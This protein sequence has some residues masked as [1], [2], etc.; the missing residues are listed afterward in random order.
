MKDEN[1]QLQDLNNTAEMALLQSAETTKAVQET[2]PALEGILIKTSELVDKLNPQEIGDN[3]SFSVVGKKGDKGDKGNTPTDDEL[4]SL[5][6][7]LIPAPIKGDDGKTPTEEELI[8]LIQPLIPA[9]I[10]GENYIL[11]EDD[12]KEIADS[13]EVPIV[14]KVIEKIEVIKE[15]LKKDTPTELKTKL[16]SLKTGLDYES[17]SNRPNIEQYIASIKQG[18]KTVSLVELDDVNLT[19]VTVTNGKYVLGSGSSS[20]PLTTKGDLYTYTTTDARLGIGTNG[21]FLKA[22]S[23][24]A[25]GLEWAAGGTG[26]VV[27]P[28][29]ATDNAITRYD[30]TTGKLIQ[31]SG[32]TLNDSGGIVAAGY[33]EAVVVKTAN[34]TA[35]ASDAL[36]LCETFANPGFTVTL[37][38][39]VGITGR[40][41]TVKDSG[42][43]AA[44]EAII[45]ACN[46]AQTIDGSATKT[47]SIAHGSI[48]VES[49]GT[50][51][52]TVAQITGTGGD[53]VLADAQTV[54]G[55]KTFLNTTMKLRNVANTFDGSFVNTNTADRIYT[56]QDRDGTLADDTDLALKAPLASPT[57]TGTV[58]VPTPSN[59]TDA[60][61]KAYVD[62]VAQGLSI[63]ESV[64]VATAATLPT[65]TYN[66]GASG[67][68]ATLTG[69]ATGVLTVDGLTVALNE[70]V[71]VKDEIT[72]AN[73]GIY[74][75][76]I[77]GA[78]GVAY[79]L[80]RS[81]NMNQAAEIPGAFTF[82]ENGTVNDSAGFVVADAGPFTIGTTAID[83]TQFSGAG[84]IIAGTG[85]T[86]TGN[87]LDVN[88]TTNRIVANAN[89]IDI[90]S[91]YV[92]QS[93]ITTLGTITTG[94]W[95]GTSIALNKI[96]AL[97][98]SQIVIT[99]ASGFLAS[100]AVATY[101]SLTELT[102][103]KGVTSA[104]QTQL[105]AKFTLPALTTGSVLFSDGTT[106]AQDNSNFFWDDTNNRLG[107][108]TTAPKTTFSILTTDTTG[109]VTNLY[110]TSTTVMSD[111]GITNLTTTADFVTSTI[112]GIIRETSVS[113]SSDPGSSKSVVGFELNTGVP[114]ALGVNLPNVN[115]TG[116]RSFVQSPGT[117]QIRLLRGAHYTVSSASTSGTIV[118]L[119][120]G[121]FNPTYSGTGTVSQ[122]DAAALNVTVSGAA[123]VTNMWST[124]G[125]MAISAGATVSTLYGSGIT[126]SQS[127]ASAVTTNGYGFYMGNVTNS[128]TF[129]NLYGFYCGYIT[130]GTN[131][132]TPFSFYASDANAYNY[133]AGNVGIG[134]TAPSTL[135]HVGLA[136]TTLGTIGVA[137]NTSGLVTIR[138]A[139]AAGTWT[140][141]LPTSSGTSGYLLQT[142]GTGVTTWAA[143]SGGA[144][145]SYGWFIS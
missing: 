49:N 5:I 35:T 66:N 70:R 101:P 96:T 53:M 108:G 118:V 14:E 104:I 102:Y 128:G 144:G 99:D 22:N 82:V 64:Q 131:T 26:D 130:A 60:S 27:G 109:A 71:L 134:T 87:T 73:N 80:T 33:A 34:Y 92:G 44:I 110:G 19:G 100:A 20:S 47:I 72:S 69:V 68:G 10:K 6:E 112:A 39:A 46:G 65:N 90:S 11:T 29:S 77:A 129:T 17:L 21:Q 135:L 25:T 42:G 9:P 31:N 58:T 16:E 50:N 57:F 15:V 13:I 76:T 117:N 48:T 38:T 1:K 74:L 84:Q 51:W 43:N 36:I 113:F 125:T 4:K 67:V 142:D 81:V 93:S 78:I 114:T 138:P 94:V 137:G 105:N 52:N 132:N 120:G 56:L 59:D 123:T 89:D 103:L 97:T 2:L 139:A 136:G 116:F 8:N 85:M 140:M 122:M 91:N 30:G 79:V 88:G 62:S 115:V 75:C 32:A 95:S 45:V 12:K 126:F 7:P 63:K 121:L 98:A 141:T 143:S 106:I 127:H 3:M 111:Y 28:G 61:T 107:L 40:R 23:A 83:W 41:Y 37:P 119:E 86:K 55:I 54:S 145:N 18:S 24:T 133:F 124:F